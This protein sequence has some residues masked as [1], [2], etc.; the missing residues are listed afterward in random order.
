[1]IACAS[2]GA[3]TRL[4]F[5]HEAGQ[6]SCAGPCGVTR[7]APLPQRRRRLA[8]F[9]GYLLDDGARR[10]ASRAELV[11]AMRLWREHADVRQ[12]VAADA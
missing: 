8:L 11:E 6:W 3:S 1:M 5:D 4:R 7:R 9:H 10:R 2:C 12:G